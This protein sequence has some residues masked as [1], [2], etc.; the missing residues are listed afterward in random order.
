M[1]V[2][3]TFLGV[4]RP[5]RIR[6]VNRTCRFHSPAVAM[7][8]RRDE[9]QR[10]R[11]RRPRTG[12]LLAFLS[13]KGIR[14]RAA[15]DTRTTTTDAG[16]KVTST[17]TTSRTHAQLQ[18]KR[19][20]SGTGRSALDGGEAAR[21][22]GRHGDPAPRPTHAPQDT[23]SGPTT[24]SPRPRHRTGRRTRLLQG[25]SATPHRAAAPGAG[26]EQS[27]PR[28]TAT[29]NGTDGLRTRA[30]T[31]PRT[32]DTATTHA[33]AQQAPLSRDPQRTLTPRLR[34]P[35]S[36]DADHD[37]TLDR[38]IQTVDRHAQDARHHRAARRMRPPHMPLHSRPR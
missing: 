33:T 6:C 36:G 23:E 34:L 17:L 38:D 25:Q 11:H 31:R 4:T 10:D 14:R 5:T 24:P 16:H 35:H 26:P 7:A 21:T 18:K 15:M 28:A 22:L 3:S 13:G 8:S 9:S 30:T 1:L 2:R 20:T 12:P 19:A 29:K 27:S 37:N 32:L